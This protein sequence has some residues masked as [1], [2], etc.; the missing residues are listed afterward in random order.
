MAKG[1]LVLSEAFIEAVGL[2]HQLVTLK[3]AMLNKPH[4]TLLEPMF[5]IHTEECEE[6][7]YLDKQYLYD[8]QISLKPSYAGG[9]KV[10]LWTYR[11]VRYR[12]ND[13]SQEPVMVLFASDLFL[14]RDPR[15]FLRFRSFL[16]SKRILDAQARDYLGKN[17]ESFPQ[18]CQSEEGI[19][20]ILNCLANITDWPDPE[21]GFKKRVGGEYT[22]E[23]V[24]KDYSAAIV[25]VRNCKLLPSE[26]LKRKP[27]ERLNIFR[28]LS[29]AED[30]EQ[31]PQGLMVFLRD[32]G[33]AT[34]NKEVIRSTAS[35]ASGVELSKGL[36]A[37]R[38]YLISNKTP[39]VEV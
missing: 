28:L 13:T 23:G 25:A 36:D 30:P 32:I 35:I 12:N 33:A 16:K 21:N 10:L 19:A 29:F 27:E 8:H 1:A 5:H 38:R 17:H 15:E 9:E 20:V 4:E 14:M 2:R 6:T 11:S 22:Q 24:A 26:L 39:S 37:V 7:I 31:G 34:E 3:K 18:L